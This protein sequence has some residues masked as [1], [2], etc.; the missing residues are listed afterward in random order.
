[1]LTGDII[2]VE[3]GPDNI[4][5]MYMRIMNHLKIS[6]HLKPLIDQNQ[7]KQPKKMRKWDRISYFKGIKGKI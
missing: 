1:M 5:K 2:G 6:L 3:Y 7:S 4:K